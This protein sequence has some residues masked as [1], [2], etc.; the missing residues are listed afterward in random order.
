MDKGGAKLDMRGRCSAG[1]KVIFKLIFERVVSM[2]L[3]IPYNCYGI[4]AM[5]AICSCPVQ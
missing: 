5:W 4:L 2:Y 3:C 1:Q